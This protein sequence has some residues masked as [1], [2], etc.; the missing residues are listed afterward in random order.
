VVLNEKDLM[1]LEKS[2]KDTGV[3]WQQTNGIDTLKM[4]LL[5]S[6]YISILAEATDSTT[7]WPP[8][9]K[10]TSGNYPSQFLQVFFWGGVKKTHQNSDC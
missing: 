4:Y 6:L 9:A 2:L 3:S 7:V 5:G 10:Y 1:I 8:F